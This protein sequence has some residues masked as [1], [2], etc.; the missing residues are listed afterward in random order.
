[1][2]ID[3]Y[4]CK[5]LLVIIFDGR[6]SRM[7]KRMAGN[8]NGIFRKK[9]VDR[10]SSPERLD[11]YIRVAN[12]SVW[13]TLMA[14]II[15]LIGIV[16]WGILGRLDTTVPVCVIAEGNEILGYI[17]DGDINSVEEGMEVLT[18]T[19][20]LV[21]EEVSK[22]P[23]KIESEYIS[24]KLSGEKSSWGYELR[25]SGEVNNGIYFGDVCVDSINPISYVIN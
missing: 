13:V 15:L 23:I 8:K 24:D 16:V 3:V 6:S 9:S 25:L 4:V 2:K 7:E 20:Q 5:L 10:I 12:P 19:S 1:M 18:D 22:T 11:E 17:S 21:I 14:L